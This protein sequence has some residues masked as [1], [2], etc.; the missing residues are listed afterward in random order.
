MLQIRSV[1]DLDECADLWAKIWPQLCIFDL[2]QV[3]S[4][5]ANCFG[6]KP[7]F[8]V[9]ETGGE[10]QGLL[11]LSWIEETQ[12]YGFFPGE[13]WQGKTWLEQNKI[14][15]NSAQ[16]MNAL[17]ESVSG[18]MHL[19]YLDPEC[20]PKECYLMAIDEVG[21]LF[22]PSRYGFSFAG[23]M[24]EFSGKTRKKIRKEMDVLQKNGVSYRHNHF[25]DIELMYEMNLEGFG[26]Y[27]YFS[28]PRFLDSYEKLVSW[29]IS[30]NMLRVTTVL[31]GQKV[32][33]VDI[34]TVWNDGYAV[35]AG[36]TN[37]EFPGVAKMINLHHIQ[38][39]C[40]ECL[41]FVDF[42]CGDF[43]W[44][45]RFHLS[46]RPLFEIQRQSGSSLQAKIA[47]N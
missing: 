23:Y 26:A 18:P 35:L 15:S 8:L 41:G 3:R 38:W 13:T 22:I 47:Q 46:S 34:G 39:A 43:N 24:E 9:A 21:Y 32:A 19:R 45:K 20:V 29:L 28:D 44:K 14:P 30:K 6:R 25:S 2:W 17:L 37:R 36:G 1:E 5:F 10:I 42:L 27:S 7:Y 11:A 16:V 4:T 40:E 31:L 33:A 12:S